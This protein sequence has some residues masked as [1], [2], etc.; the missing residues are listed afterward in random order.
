ME[1]AV[2]DRMNELEAEHW[3]FV[4]RR[5][6]IASLID[7]TLPSRNG[8]TML[9]TNRPSYTAPGKNINP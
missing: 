5:K 7:R 9:W 6:I 4:A 3:W 1:H 2:Y 8:A